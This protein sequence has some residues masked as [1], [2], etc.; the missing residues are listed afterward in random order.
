MLWFP[1]ISAIVFARARR[2]G[3]T[4]DS[5][6]VVRSLAWLVSA[7]V[8]GVVRDVVLAGPTALN[9]PEIADQFGCRA[10]EGETE[11]AYLATAIAAARG[12]HLLLIEIGAQPSGGMLAE[13]DRMTRQGG[14]DALALLLAAPVTRLQRLLPG[15][16]PRVGLLAPAD[17]CRALAGRDFAAL[18]AAL[19]PKAL[20]ATRADRLA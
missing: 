17:R 19:K 9:L 11:A 7:V 10:F 16:T 15:R 12:R 3:A 13:L 14:P 4:L 20:L 18:C 5:E 6:L 8:A 1:M 2:G